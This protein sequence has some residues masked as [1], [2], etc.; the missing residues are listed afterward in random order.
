MRAVIGDSTGC[1]T[2]PV[3]AY[4]RR[5]A[6]VADALAACTITTWVVLP[7]RVRSRDASFAAAVV[8]AAAAFFDAEG[9]GDADR[10][11]GTEADTDGD[12]ST[13][14]GASL[15]ASAVGE[16]TGWAETAGFPPQ[17]VTAASTATVASRA[18]GARRP[19][20]STGTTHSIDRMP[21]R[22]PTRLT[23][24]L[25]LV[26]LLLGGCGGGTGG[27][28]ASGAPP[29]PAVSV[30][31]PAS[32][33]ASPA[34]SPAQ[35]AF[36]GTVEALPPEVRQ[37]M[38]GVSWRPGC[39]VGLDDLRLL[40]LSYVDFAGA[41]QVGE[42]V[43]HRAIADAVVRVFAK[44]YAARFPIRGM[45]TVEAYD[46]SDDASMA[47]D[48]TSGFNCRNVPNTKHWS[49]HAY[50]RAID[51]NTVE[52]P[53]LQGTLIMPPAGKDYLDRRNVRTGMIV[54]GD[55]VVTAF[56]SEGFAWGGAWRTGVDYQHFEK[57]G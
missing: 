44:L 46:G 41:A 28:P 10:D 37:R 49:N 3:F 21:M 53:Y 19:R 38:T 56:K 14:G 17:A 16:A 32:Q 54:A 48:N 13:D 5:L 55:A 15:D 57:P 24:L 12:A 4:A 42:L 1:Q 34:G 2:P 11:A 30:S 40:R 39:P 45:R 18:F 23:P 8:P 25:A 47:A 36:V 43:V 29:S 31:A 22:V 52:N 26:P 7:G 35:T 9:D 33:S 50:G 20:W 6:V 51:V 27:S